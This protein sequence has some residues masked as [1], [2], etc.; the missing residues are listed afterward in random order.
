MASSTPKLAGNDRTRGRKTN[1]LRLS[2]ANPASTTDYA[3]II[4]GDGAPSGAYGRA[5]GT[6]MLYLRKDASNAGTAVYATA[7][8]GTTWTPMQPTGALPSGTFFASTEQTGTGASQDI[9]HGLG[10]TPSL[11]WWSISD[12]AAGLAAGPPPVLSLVPGAHDATNIKMTVSTGV[13]FHVYAV[14]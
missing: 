13:K 6:T 9:A 10:S 8:G 4:V 3:D 11:V 14:K 12:A 1:F 2:D 7:N 5:A